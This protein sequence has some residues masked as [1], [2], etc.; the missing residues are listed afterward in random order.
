MEV[1]LSKEFEI[2]RRQSRPIWV[3][4]AIGG[5]VFALG[6]G[7]LLL[8]V[9]KGWT[10]NTGVDVGLAIF[11]G[12]VAGISFFFSFWVV[13]TSY[14]LLIED[15]GLRF[16]I[17]P[18][19]DAYLSWTDPRVGF[20]LVHAIVNP[21]APGVRDADHREIYRMNW[22]IMTGNGHGFGVPTL[23]PKEAFM[24]ILRRARS[25]GLKVTET[26]TTD[27]VGLGPV[28]NY[29]VSQG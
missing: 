16:S 6:A 24:E 1:D 10:Q 27:P 25:S 3:I 12:F 26:T 8:K 11:C 18:G 7:Y 5:L 15:T 13:R 21:S 22:G 9:V 14:R 20:L 23:L 29:A 4:A 2:G 17:K 28:T 19:P